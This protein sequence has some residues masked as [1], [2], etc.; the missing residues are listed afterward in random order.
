M[1]LLD[2]N[3]EAGKKA[4]LEK[5]YVL[6]K[7]DR[8]AL[9]KK[10]YEEPTWIHFGAGNIFRAYQADILEKVLDQGVYDRGVIVAEGFDY[11]IIDKAYR[12]F[13]NLTLS[14]VMHSD[15]SI[16]KNIIGSM[17]ES[18]KCDRS[19]TED[20]ARLVAI[21]Q[22]PSLQFVTFSITEKGYSFNDADIEAGTNCRFMMGKLT[23]LL[24]ERFNAG[25]FPITLQSTDNCSHNGD[26]VKA[27]VLAYA[28][29]FE[30]K[31]IAP[32]GFYAYVSDEK[33]VSY[34]WAMIDKITPRPDARIREMLVADG[35]EDV[36]LIETDKH[37]FTAPF[38]NSEEV[39]YLVI[40][41]QNPNG[42]PPLEKGG[43][44]FA[45]KETV[46]KIERMKV[47]TC[48]NPLHTAM[49]IYGCMLGYNLISA[50]MADADLKNFI[51]GIGYV[52]GMPVVV[53]P[54]VIDP[55]KF[56]GEVVEKRLPNPFMP[57]APQRIST[58]TSQKLPIRFGG[59][60]KE[61]LKKGMDVTSLTLIP[62]VFAG[63]AR[64]LRALD[65]NG[66]EMPLSSDPLLPELQPIVAGLEL[67]KENDYSCLKQLFSRE[68]ILG[69]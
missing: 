48:L 41:N 13:D 12:P 36:D 24:V 38:V 61:Y 67:G 43:V 2:I 47:G 34:P 44:L 37:S 59:T 30:E 19:F 54:G 4:F 31:G 45:D 15:G 21:F 52:E 35:F 50:E 58:D 17:T 69:S 66:N 8:E 3:T 55:M 27:A 39:G 60:L 57:D 56:I 1:K 51:M 9:K 46:D 11:E 63:Y 5:G 68:D 20:W 10:T 22:A 53:N 28:K 62:L 16:E 25:A 7:F 26:K 23:W 40:E 6:P 14:V 49:S 65:D 29:A 32:V 42:R 33:K 64:F 18:L